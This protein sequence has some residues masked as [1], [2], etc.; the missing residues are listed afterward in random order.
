MDVVPSP[1]PSCGEDPRQG[2]EAQRELALDRDGISSHPL[3]CSATWGD[4]S[5][6]SH[7]HTMRPP[8][9]HHT[10]APRGLGRPGSCYQHDAHHE[11]GGAA[12][13]SFLNRRE[14]WRGGAERAGTA[15]FSSCGAN[16]IPRR[17]FLPTPTVVYDSGDP[18]GAI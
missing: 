10:Y 13:Q 7:H 2:R 9:R 1:K 8:P 6:P 12:G 14:Q 18:P 5:K 3:R 4:L 11:S 17:R 16:L 15:F